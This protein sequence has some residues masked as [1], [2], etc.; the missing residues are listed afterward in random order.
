MSSIAQSARAYAD[1]LDR[2]EAVRSYIKADLKLAGEKVQ[3]S[4]FTG[5]ACTGYREL[6]E[7]V[8][9]IVSAEW[10]EL[11]IRAVANMDAAQDRARSHME[12]ASRMR[13][14]PAGPCHFSGNT[15]FAI[16]L[17]DGED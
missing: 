4:W 9:K 14:T 11:V 15:Q 16:T 7:E 10:D 6:A 12:E 17:K 3:V 5:S 1:A 2:L 8:S 13:S